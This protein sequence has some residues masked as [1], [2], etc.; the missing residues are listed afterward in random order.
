MNEQ[1]STCTFEPE[2]GGASPLPGL[3]GLPQHPSRSLATLACRHVLGVRVDG[4][5]YPHATALILEWASRGE[6]RYVCEVPVNGIME[7][8]DHP[9]FRA[10]LNGADLVTP[11]GMPIVWLLRWLGLRGQPRV[12]GPELMLEV[13]A[14]AARAHVPVG[15]YGGAPAALVRLQAVLEERY[16]GL[17]IVYA[18]S[19]P[20]RAL[21]PAEEENTALEI[22]RSGC[23]ILFVGLG[24]PK[25]ER[26]MARHRGRLPA[27]MLGV[28]AAFDF[29]SGEKRQAYPWMQAAGLEWL[30]RWV[31]EPRRLFFRYGYHNPRFV[32]LAAGQLLRS[33][34]K[35]DQEL[36]PAEVRISGVSEINLESLKNRLRQKRFQ[37]LLKRLFDLTGS[38]LAIVVT[39]PLWL[40]IALL[41][42]LTSRG[43]VLFRQARLGWRGRSFKMLKFRSMQVETD[44]ALETARQGA[45]AQGRLLKTADDSRVTRLGG[46]LRR[47]SL[48]ELP[49]LFNVLKG[50]MSL[51]GPRPLIPFMLAA[52]PEFARARAL[53]RPGI[54]GLWQVSERENNTTAQAMMPYDVGYIGRFTLGLDARILLRTVFIVLSGH[55]AY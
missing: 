44:A 45:L 7:A 47:T 1:F 46:F 19:P 52:H 33:W 35:A 50:E 40:T 29:I 18:V 13:C 36:A 21:T 30:F 12:Y 26:W 5:S 4:T 24:C 43:P 28:G 10:V 22:Q 11:G 51:V 34:R 25:Q 49:Q 15:L 42:K 16:P 55:G 2:R 20:F 9:E 8:Y 41:V 32:F 6:S 31:Q 37:L 38:A 14:V 3:L 53:M 17:N 54:S 27:V 23:R 48:D 39:A